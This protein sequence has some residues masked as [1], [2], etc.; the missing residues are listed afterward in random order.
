M[1]SDAG[2]KRRKSW[3]YRT[4]TNA[5]SCCRLGERTRVDI[6]RYI[7]RFIGLEIDESL[8]WIGS[9]HVSISLV[10]TLSSES[11][12]NPAGGP[13]SLR[14]APV[15]LLRRGTGD[16]RQTSNLFHPRSGLGGYG[17]LVS[18]CG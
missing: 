11:S 15:R 13:R 5:L 18:L 1:R 14:P 16:D 6:N 7:T 4:E 2:E 8:F 17:S 12:P 10:L 3:A 9:A